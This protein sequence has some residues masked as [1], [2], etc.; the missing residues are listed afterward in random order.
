MALKI[1]TGKPGSGKSYY[2]VRDIVFKLRDWLEEE[3]KLGTDNNKILYTN[4]VLDY[5]AIDDYLGT[6]D[7]SYK[8]ICYLQDEFFCDF[9]GRFCCWWEKF[10]PNCYIVL[11]EVQQYINIHG[12]KTVDEYIKSFDLWISTHRHNGQELRFIT[13]HTDN[14]ARST[15]AMADEMYRV[16]NIKNKV[17]PI[18]GIPLADLGRVKQAFGFSHQYAIVQKGEYVGKSWRLQ[19]GERML[20]E[21]GIYACYKSINQDAVS[22]SA[23]LQLTPIGAIIW[24][25]KKH[26]W[27]LA[28]KG[29][30]AFV[31]IRCII[32]FVLALPSALSN[33]IKDANKT[34]IEKNEKTNKTN[35]ILK[36]Q[37]DKKPIKRQEFVN[38]IKPIDKIVII[39]SDYIYL[40]NGR[41]YHINDRVIY[42]G[43]NY[44]LR[45][46]N[47]FDR[48]VD[49][50]PVGTDERSDT[51][52]K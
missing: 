14:I 42:N 5:D 19:F 20:L 51:Y 49:L 30:L 44:L 3:R 28:I 13:Q 34:S 27:H 21:P 15:L 18:L 32:A 1:I 26:F 10:K 23:D 4:I 2:A 17:I 40:N 12:Q 9:N 50:V 31:F 6:S 33:A 7:Y 16:E 47:V 46:V 24:F 8:K 52:S 37:D 29:A 45:G 41:K 48:V 39:G 11:D 38:D 22:D 25:V 35:E 36:V 43:K